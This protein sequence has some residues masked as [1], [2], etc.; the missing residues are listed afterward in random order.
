MNKLGLSASALGRSGVGVI[1]SIFLCLTSVATAFAISPAT[2][3]QS[4]ASDF[5]AGE[6]ASASIKYHDLLERNLTYPQLRDVLLSYCESALREGKLATAESLTVVAREKLSDPPAIGR[7]TFLRAEILYFKGDMKQALD[8]YMDF[9]SGNTGSPLVNDV[10]DRLLLID[11]NGGDNGEPLVAYSR[12]EFLE[13]AGM[14]D[15]AVAALREL[16]KSFPS[17]QI[18]D[19]VRMK[20]GDILSS[21]AK[22]SE[23]V[24]EYRVLESSLPKSQLV[25]LAKLKIAQLYLDRLREPD[26][27]TAEYESIVTSFPET[28]FAA[29]ARSELHKLKAG[30]RGRSR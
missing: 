11:E 6:F 26:K 12:A 16:L 28:S 23:A 8:E 9:L 2:L 18:A 19:D 17:S 15:S 30:P 3:L 25:P 29:E 24:E 14:P 10:I 13:F 20:I 7:V 22:F 21:Q 5:R 1:C 4:A 27:A